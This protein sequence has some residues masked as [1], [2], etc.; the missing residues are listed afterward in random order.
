MPAYGRICKGIPGYA[1]ICQDM[2]NENVRNIM[3]E[4]YKS[5]A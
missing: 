5:G 1:R 3:R 2:Q 4:I